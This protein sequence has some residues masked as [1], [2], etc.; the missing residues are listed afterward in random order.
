MR[1]RRCKWPGGPSR[2]RFVL[3]TV[4]VACAALLAAVTTSAADQEPNTVVV[5]GDDEAIIA[6]HFF[7]PDRSFQPGD[8][9]RN[10][11]D[12]LTVTAVGKQKI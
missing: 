3:T 10:C 5:W 7:A 6:R 11:H 4:F 12:V 8:V 2:L 1:S 9:C